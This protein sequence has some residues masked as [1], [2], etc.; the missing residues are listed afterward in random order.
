MQRHP[1]TGVLLRIANAFFLRTKKRLSLSS[2]IPDVT[3]DAG[4]R[5]W[6]GKQGEEQRSV[7]TCCSSYRDRETGREGDDGDGDGDGSEPASERASGAH[8]VKRQEAVSSVRRDRRTSFLC[9][10]HFR[11]AAAAEIFQRMN[12]EKWGWN[13]A[14]RCGRMGTSKE[15]M[16]ETVSAADCRLKSRP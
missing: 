6:T 5:G 15:M 14:K 8:S 3:Q 7:S 1:S 12:E 10:F 13:V 11:A 9:R 4:M 16:R 2:S